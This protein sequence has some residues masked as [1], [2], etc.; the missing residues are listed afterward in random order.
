MTEPTELPEIGYQVDERTMLLD[1]LDYQRTVLV[2]K[3]E[4]LAEEEGARRLPPSSLTL[5][6][7]LKHLALVESHWA[8]YILQG[9]ELAEPWAEAPW[10]D[11]P[12]W[13]FNTA[14]ADSFAELWTLHRAAW[15]D[16]NSA[17][18]STAS[19]DDLAVRPASSGEVASVRWI[20]LH[21]I[22]EYARHVGHA[23]FLRQ[24]IDGAVDD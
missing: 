6:G 22:E 1:F 17:Y 20:L 24:A 3:T 19:L 18:R 11:D 14:D 10:D 7:L 21:M 8:T 15:T 23:D 4:G 12:D 9:R 5:K 2:R 13:D 16:A